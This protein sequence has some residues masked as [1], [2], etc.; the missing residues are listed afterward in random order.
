MRWTTLATL[1]LASTFLATPAASDPGPLPAPADPPPA[2]AD[3]VSPADVSYSYDGIGKRDPFRSVVVGPARATEKLFGQYDLEQ[4]ELR[5]VVEAPDANWAVIE[6]PGGFHTL[7]K[8]GSRF[9]SDHMRVLA[10]SRE[11]LVL[12][13]FR[14]TTMEGV[15]VTLRHALKLPATE[16]AL[17]ETPAGP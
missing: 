15:P 11:E 13:D 2:A 3:R 7:V 4:L 12:E 1:A 6:G 8:A 9:G 5:A 16:T 14:Y 10:V 17:P